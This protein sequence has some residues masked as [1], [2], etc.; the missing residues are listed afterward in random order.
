MPL[1]I[2][3]C[4]ITSV[5]NAQAAVRAGADALGFM[6]YADSP[7]HVSPDL[8]ADI[9]RRLPPFVAKVGVFVN[10]PLETVHHITLQCSLD[11][12]QFHGDESPDYCSSLSISACKRIKAIRVR[13][14]DSLK[15]LTPYAD[16]VDAF[17]L[18]SYDPNQLGGTGARFNW[19]LAVQAKAAGRP[20]ILAGGLNPDNIAEAVQQVAPYGVDVSSG[21][22]V[23]PGIKDADSMER[24][25]RKAHQA[26]G[27]LTP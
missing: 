22:E 16:K 18:D 15:G 23:S 27:R 20:V 5:N 1:K 21:V 3:I 8:A 6:F 7:R 25:V 13:D 4:G 9:I 12:L 17:L 11:T 14:Q 19:D 2:K 24:F 10:A 26:A